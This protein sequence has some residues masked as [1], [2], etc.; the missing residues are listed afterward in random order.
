MKKNNLLRIT[1][2]IRSFFSFEA[3]FILFLFAGLYKGDPFISSIIPLDLT[4]FFFG[5][6]SVYCFYILGLKRNWLMDRHA[7]SVNGLYILFLTYMIVSLL[8]SPSSVYASEKVLFMSSTVFLS[9][10]STSVII[11]SSSGRIKRFLQLT[12]I[13]GAWFAAQVG[14]VY[15]HSDRAGFVNVMG[16]SY[17]GTGQLISLGAIICSGYMLFYANSVVKKLTSLIVYISM[18]SSLLVLGGR[19]PLIG[20][21][22][23]LLVP[24]FYSLTI[25]KNQI[26]MKSYAL[27]AL[28]IIFLLISTIVYLILTNQ[29][30]ITLSRL[31]SFFEGE[32][33]TSAGVRSSYYWDSIVYWMKQPIFG[34]GIGS[35]PILHE[36][37]DIRNYPHNIF[38]EVASEL[39][40]IGLILLSMLLILS[41][42]HLFSIQKVNENKVN[43]MM[44]MMFV[45]SFF[46]VLV[47]GDLPDN[48]LFFAMLGLLCC[49]NRKAV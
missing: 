33:V 20:T 37:E 15:V 24:L 3:V 43:L 45:S 35:W 18:L 9:I 39:G 12:F 27:T 29:P 48:R 13:L 30:L 26:K 8:W 6:S 17:L 16:S 4:L 7:G 46:N 19:G 23:A 44:I 49:M 32:D 38:L 40:L 22:L 41:T 31:M 1:S 2:F 28:V 47:S 34:N 10:F 5:L 25:Q 42:R 21:F 14:I 11:A 36:G